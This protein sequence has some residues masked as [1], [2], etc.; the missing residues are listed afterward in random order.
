MSSTET[1]SVWHRSTQLVLLEVLERQ[2]EIEAAIEKQSLIFITLTLSSWMI[3]D[4]IN[5]NSEILAIGRR[6]QG[7][8]SLQLVL[9]T[10]MLS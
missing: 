8:S 9:E 10:T 2:A 7:R 1:M 3:T 5:S 4:I 6:G